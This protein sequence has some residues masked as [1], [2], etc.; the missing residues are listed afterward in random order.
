MVTRA[1]IHHRY[2]AEPQANPDSTNNDSDQSHCLHSLIPVAIDKQQ[3][4]VAALGLCDQ[5]LK[6]GVGQEHRRI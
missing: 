1:D 6:V 5:C 4:V 3:V 2:R